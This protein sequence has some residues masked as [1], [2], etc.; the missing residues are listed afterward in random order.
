MQAG[1]YESIALICKSMEE[2]KRVKKYFDQDGGISVRLLTGEE[3]SYRG[4]VV[5][6]PSYVAKGLEFDVVFIIAIEDK[7]SSADIDVKL[8][9]V[10]MTRA[11]HKLYV[12]YKQNTIPLMNRIVQ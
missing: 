9:Y 5:L 12:Y 2:C 10:A 11:L 7:Y 8:L 3:V 1:G 4:G 6:V